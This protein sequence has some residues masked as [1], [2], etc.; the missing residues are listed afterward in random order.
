MYERMRLTASIKHRKQVCAYEKMCAY[1]YTKGALN[2]LSLRYVT[3]FLLTL[4]SSKILSCS[5][6]TLPLSYVLMC[7]WG[8]HVHTIIAVILNLTTHHKCHPH[9]H[10][11]VKGDVRY[12][13]CTHV[14]ISLD[15]SHGTINFRVCAKMQVQFKGGNKI[16]VGSLLCWCS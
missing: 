14:H 7:S 1:M 5:S 16:R 13:T 6:Y 10:Y 12:S 9:S 4:H 2:N 15:T 3:C 8:V 11:M